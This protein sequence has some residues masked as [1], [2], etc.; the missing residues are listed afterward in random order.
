MLARKF[1]SYLLVKDSHASAAAL[2]F[3][4]LPFFGIPTGFMAAAILALVVLV[5]E[6]RS[7]LMVL[8]WAALPTLCL[9]YLHQWASLDLL[10]LSRFIL[11]LCFALLLKLKKSWRLLLEVQALLGLVVVSAFHWLIPNLNQWWT[12]LLTGYVQQLESNSHLA[13]TQ[14]QWQS[15]IK[16]ALPIMTGSIVTGALAGLTVLL[17]LASWWK[18]QIFKPGSF[19]KEFRSIRMSLL[20]AGVLLVAVVGC[21]LHWRGLMDALPVLIFP[22]MVAGLSLLH[23]GANRKKPKKLMGKLFLNKV[24]FF[25]LAASYLGLLFVPWAAALI[26]ALLGF[27]DSGYSIRQQVFDKRVRA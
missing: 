27:I 10:S 17:V 25:V 13:L 6:L 16:Q 1:G 9:L 8:A 12:Q 18:A 14:D 4:F 15:F 21:L 24:M 11:I 20:D 23:Y 26:L 3:A 19:G 22:F 5:K 2:I 7:S